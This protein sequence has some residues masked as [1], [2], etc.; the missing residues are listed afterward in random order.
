MDSNQDEGEVQLRFGKILPLLI[1]LS[2]FVTRCYHVARNL[3]FQ[4]ASLYNPQQ[5]LYIA[6][7]KAVHL[8]TVYEA[9]SDLFTV[10]ITL[11]Q[12]I[13]TNEAI[14]NALG[15]YKRY[16]CVYLSPLCIYLKIETGC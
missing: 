10:L 1:D 14:S 9:L 15:M 5:K 8:T 12:T 3:V 11:D 7:F 16:V 6:S 4:M 2:K 13:S